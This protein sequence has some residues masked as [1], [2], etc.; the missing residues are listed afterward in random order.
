MQVIDQPT[1]VGNEFGQVL[2]ALAALKRGERAVRLPSEWSGLPGKVADTFDDVASQNERMAEELARLRRVVGKQGKLLERGSIG[3]VRGFWRESIDDLQFSSHVIEE[4]D[5]WVLAGL[6]VTGVGRTSGVPVDLDAVA[7]IQ[8]R[9]GKLAR[10][11]GYPSLEEARAG[12]S[13]R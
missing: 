6:H 8:M 1:L 11:V 5:G 7:A 12:V 3:D 4:C 9:D 2:N 13:E 10:M